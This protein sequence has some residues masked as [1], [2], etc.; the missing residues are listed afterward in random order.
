M[1]PLAQSSVPAAADGHQDVRLRRRGDGTSG[2]DHQAVGA[3]REILETPGVDAGRLQQP[4][5]ALDVSRSDDARIRNDQRPRRVDVAREFADARQGVR[6][7]HDPCPGAEITRSHP[8]LRIDVM[9]H[10]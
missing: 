5:G 8:G 6:S 10:A 9:A 7:E 4:L 3:G 1:I 2:F